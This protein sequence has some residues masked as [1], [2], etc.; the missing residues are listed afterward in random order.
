M[1][2]ADAAP[3]PKA[4]VIQE[5]NATNA[6]PICTKTVAAKTPVSPQE[7]PK[8]TQAT[9]TTLTKKRP[10]AVKA[11]ASS[12]NTAALVA[13]A[14]KSAKKAPIKAKKTLKKKKKKF[15]SILSGMMKPKKELDVLAE[16][17]SLRKTLGGG[18]FRK[19]DKI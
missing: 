1:D 12:S 11:V 15:S 19:V 5:A 6:T 8:P 16:R 4:P 9:A 14:L 3:P 7:S 10:L 18:N 13:P 2:S 17:E